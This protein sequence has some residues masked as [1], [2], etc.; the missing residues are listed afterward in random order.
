MSE[1]QCLLVALNDCATENEMIFTCLCVREGG[2]RRRRLQITLASI[3]YSFVNGY[4]QVSADERA[5]LVRE[6][7]CS[8]LETS[9]TNFNKVER[10]FL[11]ALSNAS[12]A[13]DTMGGAAPKR[14]PSFIQRLRTRA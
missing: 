14:R 9:A 8:F 13:R 3:L 5:R 1:Q 7:N 4:L 6:M 2:A 12:L 10:V 11:A